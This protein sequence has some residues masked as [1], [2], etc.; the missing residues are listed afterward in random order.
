MAH[1]NNNI[2]SWKQSKINRKVQRQSKRDNNAIH[3][4]AE[5][6]AAN[7]LAQRAIDEEKY[8][9]ENGSKKA[10]QVMFAIFH[11]ASTHIA[12]Y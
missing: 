12:Y 11:T 1:H 5:E 4:R 9:Q 3:T 7:A 8:R 6:D 10:D 2:K